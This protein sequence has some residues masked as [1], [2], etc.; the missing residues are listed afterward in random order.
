MLM[1][2][3]TDGFTL[4]AS[5]LTLGQKEEEVENRLEGLFPLHAH[6]FSKEI[7]KGMRV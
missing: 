2:L 3:G 1:D 4:L 5:S 6:A 7:P